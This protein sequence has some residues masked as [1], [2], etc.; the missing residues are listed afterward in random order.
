MGLLVEQKISYRV[1]ILYGIMDEST[2]SYLYRSF[3]PAISIY[4]CLRSG[5]VDIQA[6]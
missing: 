5:S 6:S 1:F 3:V 4:F 2:E